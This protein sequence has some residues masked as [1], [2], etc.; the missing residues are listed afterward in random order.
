[1]KRS[2][3]CYEF[4]IGHRSNPYNNNS[5]IKGEHCANKFQLRFGV[6]RVTTSQNGLCWIT[7]I[8]LLK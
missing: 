6:D 5:A 3:D 1:M 8:F 2:T 7:S 4:H